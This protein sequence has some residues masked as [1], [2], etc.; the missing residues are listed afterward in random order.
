[1]TRRLRTMCFC[2][3]AALAFV[4]G[5]S[6]SGARADGGPGADYVLGPYDEIQVSVSYHEE[7][8][9]KLIVM[10]DGKIGYPAVGELRAAGKTPKQ[11]GADI[12][13]SLE[14]TLNNAS[15]VVS[16]LSVNSQS[17]RV[18]GAVKNQGA[19]P[20]RR[21]M[22]VTDAIALAGGL[23]ARPA[24]VNARLVKRSGT[25]V[26]ISV[27]DLLA[28]P[29]GPKNLTLDSDDLLIV[30]ESDPVKN[31]VFV[32]GEVARPGPID[33]G[34]EGITLL[35]LLAAAGNIAPDAALTKCYVQ[36][37]QQRIPV[38]LLP[39]IAQGKQDEPVA[40]MKL[41]AGDVLM[42]PKIAGRFAVVGQVNRAGLFPLSEERDLTAVDALAL[43][44][45]GTQNAD[46]SKATLLRLEA[47]KMQILP[48]NLDQIVKR[49]DAS[50]NMVIQ[51]DDVVYVPMRGQRGM[52]W[53]DLLVPLSA[54]RWATGT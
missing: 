52:T 41:Q 7:L 48:L 15:V 12:Q 18:V 44:A 39:L 23:I 16:V 35:S 14:K 26:P 19:F 2:A 34:D 38:N 1:M 31:K 27:P 17:I 20:F 25:L 32:M 47:G 22:K 49:H 10:P 53:S 13:A 5:G 28:E 6:H 42:I 50:K 3:I 8:N 24:Q 33:L 51:K 46:L 36:R 37:G 9:A 30:D 4:L 29:Q 45:G 43:A 21:E 11:L 40:A 54:L